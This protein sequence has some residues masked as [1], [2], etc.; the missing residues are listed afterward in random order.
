MS[1]AFQR[2][3]KHIND[4]LG[5][6][7]TRPVNALASEEQLRAAFGGALPKAGTPPPEVVDFIAENARDGLLGSA[8]GRFFAWVIGGSVPLG[9]CCRL[10]GFGL[11]S[12]RGA[13]CLL[14]GGGRDRGCCR[15]MDQG[16]T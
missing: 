8:G 3:R 4:W 2:A 13:L 7:D 14:T 6:F 10:A 9:T 16:I 5:D 1:E 11:G 12:E 15:R